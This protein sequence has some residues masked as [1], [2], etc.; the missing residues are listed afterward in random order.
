MT[1][2]PRTPDT[3]VA[4]ADLSVRDL[5]RMTKDNLAALARSAGLAEDGS[6]ADLLDRLLAAKRGGA[7]G[8]VHGNTICPRCKKKTLY[9]NGRGE[10][11]RY[12]K[13][14]NSPCGARI[15]IRIKQ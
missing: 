8:Y 2:A 14:V 5:R 11:F 7:E 4:P 1:D 12:F 6:K 3:Q 15:K 13:C 9:C 10:V